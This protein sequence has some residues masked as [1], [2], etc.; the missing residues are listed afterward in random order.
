[1]TSNINFAG[2]D[3]NYPV[4]GQDN[5]SQGFRDNFRYIQDSLEYAKSEIEDLQTKSVLKGPLEDGPAV[6]NNLGNGTIYNGSFRDFHGTSHP[7]SVNELIADE[8]N[9]IDIEKGNLFHIIV[10]SGSA[11]G[12]T[13]KNWPASD[14]F[15][16]LRIHFVDNAARTITLY[17]EGGGDIVY[18]ADFPSN[19]LTFTNS[20]KHVVIDAWTYTGSAST[21]VYV[22]YVGKF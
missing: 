19:A 5:D 22:S 7:T 11:A 21:K 8:S 12:L 2:I 13:F 18:E 10:D 14:I 4:A 3:P 20:G 16:K 6:D 9:A 1:M 17:T 15:A